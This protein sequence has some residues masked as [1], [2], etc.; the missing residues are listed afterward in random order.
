[1]AI[2]VRLSRNSWIRLRNLAMDS[3]E[4]LQTLTVDGY[5]LV[6][7]EKDLPRLDV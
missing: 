5:N 4:T 2:T 7:A 6:L 1:M 3:R